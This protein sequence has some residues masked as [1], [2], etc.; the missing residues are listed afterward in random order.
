[1]LRGPAAARLPLP[2]AQRLKRSRG[3]GPAPTTVDELM[4]TVAVVAGRDLPSRRA[5]GAATT[6]TG[7]P[8]FVL[9]RPSP[10]GVLDELEI[11]LVPVLLGPGRRLFETSIPSRSS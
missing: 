9:T 8:I 7:V 10:T 11:H 2:K 5:A 6:T 4:A 3:T 1:M